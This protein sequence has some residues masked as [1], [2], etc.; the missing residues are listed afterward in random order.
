MSCGSWIIDSEEIAVCK[1]GILTDNG[2]V[3]YCGDCI[4]RKESV[5]MLNNNK[6]RLKK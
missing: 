4:R 3:Y 5:A 6:A 1:C 2:N